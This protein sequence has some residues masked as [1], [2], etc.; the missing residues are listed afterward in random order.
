MSLLHYFFDRW[1]RPSGESVHQKLAYINSLIKITESWS[2]PRCNGEFLVHGYICRKMFMNV[3]SVVFFHVRLLADRQTDRQTT[4][5]HNL[6]G[7]Q[8][9][10]RK[11]D[12]WPSGTVCKNITEVTN[13]PC[14]YTW[15]RS[16]FSACTGYLWQPYSHVVR[17][18]LSYNI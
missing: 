10:K 2:L 9:N 17:V 5:E 7:N 14:I 8:H 16:T 11:V 3:R 18:I 13:C 6:A 12:F 1:P 4:V 15:R